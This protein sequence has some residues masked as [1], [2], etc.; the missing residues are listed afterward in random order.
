[1]NSINLNGYS[2]E[3]L[4]DNEPVEKIIYHDTNY[5]ALPNNTEYMIR[6][7]NNR[8]VKT[9]ATIWI[10][11]ERVGTWRVNPYSRITV[12]RPGNMNRKFT[13]VRE[14]SYQAKQAGVEVG[15]QVN[16]LIKVEFKPEKFSEYVPQIRDHTDYLQSY[17]P[18]GVHYL[19][20]A[21]TD[22]VTPADKIHRFCAM[23][24]NSYDR[25]VESN[26]LSPGATILGNQS[27]QQFKKVVPIDNVD[28]ANITVIHT[29]L[30]VDDD[31]S[32]WRRKYIHLREANNVNNQTLVPPPINREH[33][34]RPS[35]CFVNN[36][37]A[38]QNKDWLDR[39]SGRYM[40]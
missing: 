4:T 2:L 5:Y 35:K 24:S 6:L 9:D 40:N 33:P 12:E 38:A 15:L 23:N 22:T 16:G 30:V 1:M 39:Y 25:Y 37:F 32:T 31:K 10:D 28:T 17:D 8:D 13:L 21:Y 29:R 7:T 19:C 34:S 18:T 36:N 20:K 14:T 27:N 3:V 11:N 26:L